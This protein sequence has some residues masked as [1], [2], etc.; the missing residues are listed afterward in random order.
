MFR[1]E[2][3]SMVEQEKN[4]IRNI[5]TLA[6]TPFLKI[7]VKKFCLKW[8]GFKYPPTLDYCPK[9]VVILKK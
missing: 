2:A 3:F 7:E 9:S 5:I 4:K 8:Y 1:D 6:S